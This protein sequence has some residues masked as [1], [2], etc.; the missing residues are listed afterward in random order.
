MNKEPEKPQ[1]TPQ[2]KRILGPIK[3]SFRE[4]GGREAMKKSSVSDGG[5]PMLT[6]FTEEVFVKQMDLDWADYS[7]RTWESGEKLFTM[8][9]RIF[10]SMK[11]SGGSAEL[12][13]NSFN[14]WLD[15]RGYRWQVR[16]HAKNVASVGAAVVIKSF[17]IR[18]E[19]SISKISQVPSSLVGEA[20]KD[21]G[22]IGKGHMLDSIIKGEEIPSYQASLLHVL[23]RVAPIMAPFEGQVYEGAIAAYSV[24]NSFHERGNITFKNPPVVVE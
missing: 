17:E 11:S 8:T 12:F 18:D 13:L 16:D 14:E 22:E 4:Q 15:N 7:G 6:D 21:I 24:L 20:F 5:L 2:E 9:R 1:L 19:D 3:K 23:G 10:Q